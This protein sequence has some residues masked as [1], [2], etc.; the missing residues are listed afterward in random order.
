MKGFAKTRQP[1]NQKK[2]NQEGYLLNKFR[3][4]VVAKDCTLEI[5]NKRRTGKLPKVS[6]CTS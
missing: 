5:K 1:R 3:L 6:I 2:T 4:K